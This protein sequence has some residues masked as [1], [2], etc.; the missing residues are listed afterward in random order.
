MEYLI[1]VLLV[2]AV[3]GF[4][5]FRK[6]RREQAPVEDDW[7][8]ITGTA[9]APE[10]LSRDALL[11]RAHTF[12]PDSW[13]DAAD[14]EPAPK[15]RPNRSAPAAGTR[16]ASGEG[17]PAPRPQPADDA[18]P[19]FLDRDFLKSRERRDAPLEWPED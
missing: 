12:D 19:T 17:Q 5:W 9:G 18:E 16:P 14:P 13:D 7:A 1:G 11:N 2:V 6:R 10:V 8:G 15:P 3:G 4:F